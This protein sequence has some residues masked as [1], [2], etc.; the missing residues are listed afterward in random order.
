M[1]IFE[2]WNVWAKYISY[3]SGVAAILLLLGYF[4]KLASTSDSKT[5]YDFINKSEINILWIAGIL[6]IIAGGFYANSFLSVETIP[7]ILVVR[8]FT[9]LS[10]GLIVGVVVRN[11]LKFYYPFYIEKRLK[12]RFG[13]IVPRFFISFHYSFSEL[14]VVFHS[15]GM[16]SK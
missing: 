7:M 5:K 2:T 1:E 8:L 11:L 12:K 14:L 10:M 15:L 13:N 4:I 9:T 16:S 3:A 6:L